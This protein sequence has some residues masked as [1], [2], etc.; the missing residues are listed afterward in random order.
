MKLSIK[1]KK[2]EFPKGIPACGTDALRFTL[3]SYNVSDHYI[4]FEVNMCHK[5]QLFLQKIWNATRFL[6]HNCEKIGV[7]YY[8]TPELKNRALTEIDQWILSRLANTIITYRNAMEDFKFHEATYI[9]KT[10]FYSN[11]CDVYLEAIKVHLQTSIEPFA[12]TH[13]NVLKACLL[14]GLRHIGLFTPFL[15]NELLK[16]LPSD[17]EFNVG[18]LFQLKRKM[19]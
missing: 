15:S 9:L 10:F 18:I 12:S 17:I 3:C 14:I 5:N 2:K 6:L 16:Y 11:L 7:N 8:D 1:E 13:L 4:N 19:C